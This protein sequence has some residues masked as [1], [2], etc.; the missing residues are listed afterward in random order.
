M[1]LLFGI[2]GIQAVN[3]YH[4][5][6]IRAA[7]VAE[8]LAVIAVDSS[9]DVVEAVKHKTLPIMG[10]QWRGCDWVWAACP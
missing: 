2:D 6:G 8:Q 4:N 7:Q 10:V 5:D 1:R 9:Y 3:H